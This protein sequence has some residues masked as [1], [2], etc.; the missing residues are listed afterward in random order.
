MAELIAVECP[1]CERQTVAGHR[2]CLICG[3]TIHP[4]INPRARIHFCME[5]VDDEV[6]FFKDPGPKAAFGLILIPIFGLIAFLL[7]K[8]VDFTAFKPMDWALAAVSAL[9]AIVL[10]YRIVQLVRSKSER[11]PLL[12]LDFEGINFPQFDN[13]LIPWIDIETTTGSGSSYPHLWMSHPHA[14]G[15]DVSFKVKRD[16]GIDPTRYSGLNYN[17]L[18]RTVTLAQVSIDPEFV[19]RAVAFFGPILTQ[20]R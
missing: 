16:V 5:I 14:S 8:D 9:L 10:T 4:D 13:I 2:D 18:S 17:P 19:S 1:R 6:L 20:E 11:K 7:L 15:A 12:M 3:R